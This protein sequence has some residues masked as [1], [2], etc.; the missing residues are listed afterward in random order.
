MPLY[1]FEHPIT[2]QRKTFL[3]RMNDVHKFF[4][5]EGTE[6]NRVFEIPQAK[7]STLSSIDPF[8]KNQFMDKTRTMSGTVG[9]LWDLS[10]ELSEK[11]KAKRGKDTVKEQAIK[12]YRKKTKGKLHPHE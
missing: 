3:Q 5:G 6:W 7:V 11:R 12:D 8:N 2:K 4:D 10:A 9:D 1:T